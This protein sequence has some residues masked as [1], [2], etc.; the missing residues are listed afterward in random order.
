MTKLLFNS[1]SSNAISVKD[2]NFN[3][4]HY[5]NI[6]RTSYI[7]EEDSEVYI[8]GELKDTAKAGDLI[9]LLYGIEQRYEKSE[10]IVI[11]NDKISDYLE[12]RNKYYAEKAGKET[13]SICCNNCC[14]SAN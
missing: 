4:M 14:E 7:V 9:I 6:I 5:D 10:V 8:D 2:N 13:E 1:N 12:I 3:I 11:R